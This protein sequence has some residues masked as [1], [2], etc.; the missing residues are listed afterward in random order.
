M[1]PFQTFAVLAYVPLLEKKIPLAVLHFCLEIWVHRIF[2][3]IRIFFFFFFCILVSTGDQNV[4]LRNVLYLRK[5]FVTRGDIRFN[6]GICRTVKRSNYFAGFAIKYCTH[7]YQKDFLKAIKDFKCRT[8]TLTA[9]RIPTSVQSADKNNR[10]FNTIQFLQQYQNCIRYFCIN[11]ST[12]WPA[13]CHKL[14]ELIWSRAHNK[15]LWCTINNS[16]YSGV[17]V[18]NQTRI[19]T[20]LSADSINLPNSIDKMTEKQFNISSGSINTDTNVHP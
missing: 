17:S 8:I 15:T 12:H 4:V 5:Y 3:F 14:S 10:D 19:V 2:N 6:T 20:Q 9:L 16:L 13:A 7:D 1:L 11:T 18:S